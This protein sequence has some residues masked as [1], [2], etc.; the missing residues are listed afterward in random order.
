MTWLPASLRKLVQLE[1]NVCWLP[2]LYLPPPCMW[3]QHL[4]FF[5]SQR[6]NQLS[7]CQHIYSIIHFFFFLL[8]IPISIQ[9]YYFLSLYL[10]TSL[11]MPVSS[12][13]AQCL[14]FIFEQSFSTDCLHLQMFLLLFSLSPFCWCF[15][16]QNSVGYTHIKDIDD[17]SFSKALVISPCLL[18]DLSAS[19]TFD[20]CL[21]LNLLPLGSQDCSWP[22]YLF[23]CCF[24][25]ISLTSKYWRKPRLWALFPSTPTPWWVHL[26]QSS[27]CHLSD[28]S[29]IDLQPDSLGPQFIHI[30]AI[31]N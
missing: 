11:L 14:S 7:S 31:S 5:R 18:T 26:S 19:D 21:Q 30:S 8:I 20:H 6:V 28:D 27:Q 16:P 25:L 3:A 9:A 1:G 29:S 22:G 15:C 24:L 13:T 23:L 4:A 12:W 2:P 10:K 17:I